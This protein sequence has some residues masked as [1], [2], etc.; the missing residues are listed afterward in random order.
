MRFGTPLEDAER[1]DFTVNSLFYNLVTRQVHNLVL[2]I[3]MIL[4][5]YF[6]DR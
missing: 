5:Y 6:I 3:I 2:L 1:R 4:L